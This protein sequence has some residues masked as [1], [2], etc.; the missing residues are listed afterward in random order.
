MTFIRRGILFLFCALLLCAPVFAAAP[1]VP[2]DEE[3]FG[4]RDWDAVIA[5]FFA[6]NFVDP[7][8]VGIAYC[9]TVTGETHFVNADRYRFA[10][11]IY[12]LP[13]NMYFAEQVYLGAMSMDDTIAGVP[14]RAIQ[15]L[16]LVESNNEYSEKLQLS[17]G[18]W[19][20]YKSAIAPMIAD[21]PA[22]ID[23]NET[24]MPWY[25]KFTPRQILHALSLLY[26]D[27]DRYPDVLEHMKNASRDSFLAMLERRYTIAHKPGNHI[28]PEGGLATINDCGIVYTDDPILLVMLTDHLPNAFGVMGKFC[29]LMCDWTQYQR[30]VR[31]AAEAEAAEKARLAAEAEAAEKARLAAEAEAAEKARLAAEAE[32][33]EKARLAAE[34]EAAEKARLAAEKAE[35]EARARMM[36]LVITA[37]ISA[38]LLAAILLLGKSRRAKCILT[39]ALAAALVLALALLSGCAN[40]SQSAAP[41]APPAPSTP[42]P[43]PESTPV[44]SP[45]PTPVPTPEP[46]PEPTPIPTPE[47]VRVM[48]LPREATAEDVLA[49]AEKFPEL[50]YLNGKLTDQYEAL[51]ELSRL[52]PEC[53]VDY[54]VDLG[55]VEV[56]SADESA[57]LDGAAI[58]AEEL[59]RRLAY[60]PNLK[61]IDICPLNLPD[62]D[63]IAV[64]EAFPD[65]KVVWT[66]HFGRWAVRTD[67]T[68]F[69][70]LNSPVVLELR[71]KD[72]TFAPLF[73]YCTDLVALD[74]GHNN[75]VDLSPL[76]NLTKL[77]VL[78][79]GDNPG[80]QDVSPLGALTEL[81]YME[82]FMSNIPTDY[83]CMRSMTHMTDLC[84][85]FC[86]G[87][88][89]ISF[90]DDMPEREVG[91]FPY[92]GVPD[93]QAAAMR[94]A[95]PEVSFMFKPSRFSSTADGWRETAHNLAV[96]KAFTNW[97]AVTAFRSIEDVEYQEGAWLVEVFP[98][99]F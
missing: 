17:L 49:L 39:A 77:Q 45:Q 54:L 1:S 29:T 74:L 82:F 13:L 69:S 4:G 73:T 26:A 72:D 90:I 80:I 44:P 63:C 58:G 68:C 75:I 18:T 52:L 42:E 94:A 78:I 65:K 55:G 48:T 84:I 50:R 79:L 5:D 33:A 40:A 87:M 12:K 15:R 32:A 7:E 16:S 67:A 56:G 83:S 47:P 34:A 89:D 88:N 91:W 95:R 24:W 25:S 64:A 76:A 31:L 60:L 59:I 10:A 23:P 97:R 96:R 41:T 43:A 70:T 6:E 8:T 11:S 62:S 19:D 81:R 28:D 20:D 27:P 35:K 93:E 21:D 38:I 85:G 9:N 99:R 57:V 61:R 92:D 30:S 2:S 71:Y 22:E 98:S 36:R 37:F 51:A 86:A 14:Y 66:V 53:E 46:T 3:R